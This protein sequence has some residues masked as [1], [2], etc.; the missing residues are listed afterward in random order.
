MK[1]AVGVIFVLKSI[2]KNACDPIVIVAH[3]E[4]ILLY[5]S[6]Y[7]KFLVILQKIT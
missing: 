1:V 5:F 2:K 6:Y 3:D 4:S 7:N